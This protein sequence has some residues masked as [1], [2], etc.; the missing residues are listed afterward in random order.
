M[1]AP[2]RA[3]RPEAVA[4]L[5]SR[6]AL[7]HVAV[8]VD[9]RHVHQSAD[10]AE[11]SPVMEPDFTL[12]W[13]GSDGT[14]VAVLKQGGRVG[15]GQLLWSVGTQLPTVETMAIGVPPNV[16]TI[17]IFY[18]NESKTSI[19]SATISE[20]L[21]PKLTLVAA[22]ATDSLTGVST[23][24]TEAG[25]VQTVQF[26]LVGGIAPRTQGYLEFEVARTA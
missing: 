21:N 19:T 12:M 2:R 3:Y 9:V 18:Q 8:P 5:E 22:S 20:T 14:R 26:N 16:A 7:S 6:L 11:S 1:K 24:T 25:G 23:T 10:R 17:T 4:V 15:D 13:N